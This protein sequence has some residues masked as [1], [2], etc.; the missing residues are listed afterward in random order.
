M[1][2]MPPECGQILQFVKGYAKEGR[3]PLHVAE[4]EE[5][6]QHE[7]ARWGSLKRQRPAMLS[8]WQVL[9]HLDP[10]P[11]VGAAAAAP[12]GHA[13]SCRLLHSEV[14]CGA[15]RPLDRQK[16]PEADVKNQPHQPPFYELPLV[17]FSKF[18]NLINLLG[19]LGFNMFQS[20]SISFG[21]ATPV[22]CW[23]KT[24]AWCPSRCGFRMP[25][26]T[27]R[28]E[29]VLEEVASITSMNFYVIAWS[30]LCRYTNIR[31][32]RK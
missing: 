9:A 4:E 15:L 22:R 18:E 3:P 12:C 27:S 30:F 11:V 20:C 29:H 25:A 6:L 23:K 5:I 26:V 24:G 8:L 31:I 7:N 2:I 21:L 14:L 32:R 10:F 1:G 17:W 16:A 13:G 28:K 19:W